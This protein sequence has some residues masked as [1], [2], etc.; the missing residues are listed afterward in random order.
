MEVEPGYEDVMKCVEDISRSDFVS[1]VVAGKSF[2]GRDIPMV[3]ITD[4]RVSDDD[5]QLVLLTAGTHGCEEAGRAV[6]MALMEWLASGYPYVTLRNQKFIIFPC[7]NPDGS[8]ANTYRNAED[9]NIYES[10]GFDGVPT[11]HEGRIVYDIVGDLNPAL[12]V[13]IHGLAGGAMKEEFYCHH[14]FPE[15]PTEFLTKVYAE[16]VR[17]AAE[18]AG[19]PQREPRWRNHPCL[20][21]R[22]ARA[23]NCFA[24]T[25]ET[26][27]QFY[28][29]NLMRASGT[30]RMK[31]MIAIGDRRNF[32]HY[33]Q[34]YPCEAISGNAMFWMCAHGATAAARGE[35]R[36][37]MMACMDR[38]SN[39]KRTAH[40]KGS[41]ATLTM[42][43]DEDLPE[44]DRFSL[45]MRLHKPARIKGVYYDGRELEVSEEHGFVT[46]QDTASQ[47]VRINV[48]AEGGVTKGQHVAQVRY[49]IDW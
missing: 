30:I 46:W 34:G 26:T 3:A 6:G 31:A 8:V 20:P 35:N 11:S 29:V 16:E 2:Q 33:Y 38:I 5:K 9:A 43:V 10:Y 12:T 23:T 48:F 13:D 1:V 36:R 40:D 49:D 22:M 47:L 18:A 45:Q 32:H 24:Y 27:E 19:F 42:V 15:S 4:R 44:L 37:R 39:L 14:G 25:A 21:A 7:V 17:Q 41:A 28:P